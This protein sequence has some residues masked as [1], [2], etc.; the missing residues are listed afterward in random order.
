MSQPSIRVSPSDLP[1]FNFLQYRNYLSEY[2]TEV[3]KARV[4]YNLGI[5]DTLS[6]KWGNIG[7]TIENQIDLINLVRQTV[8]N[9]FS[10]ISESLTALTSKVNTIADNILTINN[11]RSAIQIA[12][13]QYKEELERRL[14]E[15]ERE[16]SQNAALIK[17]T[18]VDG[19]VIDINVINQ[20]ITSLRDR[21]SALE[22]N[23]GQQ[24]INDLYTNVRQLMSDRTSMQT[25]I[26][27]LSGDNSTLQ[28]TVNSL[29][30]IISTLQSELSRVK[31]QVGIVN[32]ESIS[33][34]RSDVTG[35]ISGD[36]VS[37]VVTAN[38]DSGASRDVTSE[39]IVESSNTNVAV[40]NNGIQ[41]VGIGTA[42]I[43][44]SYTFSNVTTTA[45]TSVTVTSEQVTVP[46]QYVGY[47][48]SYQQVFQNNNFACDTIAGTWT[49][50]NTPVYG[51]S[52][53]AFYVI[54]TQTIN[55]IGDF[56]ANYN[57]SDLIDTNNSQVTDNQGI[58]YNVYKIAPLFDTNTDIIITIQ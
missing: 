39:C 38:F 35:T 10:P 36:K 52:P 8:D 41:F 13:Q 4:R 48:N 20:Q 18:G 45:Q 43:T 57:V 50:Q 17:L 32:L 3:D 44:Y 30:T 15:L 5:P 47:A 58:T 31:A 12:N 6:F 25:A 2:K 11:D 16:V 51:E 9:K 55:T 1:K 49:S 7:G 28:S 26:S 29:Q 34:S 19:A 56:I 24:N 40:W 37:I 33:V 14:F 46:K 54:T 21:I 23:Q 27:N 42:T 53:Y 22:N